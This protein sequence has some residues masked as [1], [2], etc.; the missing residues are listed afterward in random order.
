MPH[1]Y[2][3]HSDFSVIANDFPHLLFTLSSDKSHR[4]VYHVLLLASCLV[5][6]GNALLVDRSS[7]FFVKVICIDH[8]Y[9]AIEYTLYQRGST[10]GDDKVVALLISAWQERLT[11]VVG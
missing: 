1:K 11:L 7:T 4:G 10:L 5:R 3:P 6:L 9:H 8:D 2:T